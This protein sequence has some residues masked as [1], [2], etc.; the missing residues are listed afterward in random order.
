M[1]ATRW[2][3]RPESR[4]DER[5][6]VQQFVDDELRGD[7][8]WPQSHP[9]DHRAEDGDESGDE[10]ARPEASHSQWLCSGPSG[11]RIGHGLGPGRD[12]AGTAA[13]SIAR[14]MIR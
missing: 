5:Q 3:D 12:Q 11:A 9:D 4:F 8:D 2:A 6:V 7:V 1:M 13:E 14:A 10:R